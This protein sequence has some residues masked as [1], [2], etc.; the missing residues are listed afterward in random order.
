MK[1]RERGCR[2]ERREKER[3]REREREQLII[4]YL[5]AYLR[6]YYLIGGAARPKFLAHVSRT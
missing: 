3:E 5:R 2:E 4:T 6:Y 1:C